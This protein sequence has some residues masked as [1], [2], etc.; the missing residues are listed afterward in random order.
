M[1]RKGGGREEG[2]VGS[3]CREGRGHVEV[4]RVGAPRHE[5]GGGEEE[6]EKQK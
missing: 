5:K 2:A 6:L 1:A 3:G 4:G